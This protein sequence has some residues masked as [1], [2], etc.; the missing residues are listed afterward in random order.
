VALIPV[1]PFRQ[2][3]QLQQSYTTQNTTGLFLMLDLLDNPSPL[4]R[5]QSKQWLEECQTHFE[6]ILDPILGTKGGKGF[7]SIL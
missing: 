6:R 2:Q 4:I 5:N 1:T 7:R 3:G